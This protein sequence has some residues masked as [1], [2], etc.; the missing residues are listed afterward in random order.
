M[1]IIIHQYNILGINVVTIE[2]PKNQNFIWMIASPLRP[3]H[4]ISYST[5]G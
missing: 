3:T 4:D 1:K 5:K 2:L